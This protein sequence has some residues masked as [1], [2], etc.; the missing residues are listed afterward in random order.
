MAK[1]NLTAPVF[2]ASATGYPT[3]TSIAAAPLAAAITIPSQPDRTITAAVLTPG[4]PGLA[5][6]ALTPAGDVYSGAVTYTTAGEYTPY[7]TITWGETPNTTVIYLD[8]IT[9]T[10]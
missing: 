9:V 2:C 1:H 8:N 4:E 6:V 5:D 7:V 10:A 3:T